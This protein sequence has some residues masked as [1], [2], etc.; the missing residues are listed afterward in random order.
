MYVAALKV[1][2]RACSA[3]AK[4]SALYLYSSIHRRRIS[5]RIWKCK[6]SLWFHDRLDLMQYNRELTP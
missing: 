3:Y 5:M 6:G 1:R 4:V 2:D